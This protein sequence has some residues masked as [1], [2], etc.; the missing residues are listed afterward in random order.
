MATHPRLV[1]FSSQI[2]HSRPFP[3][4]YF[5]QTI[6]SNY[7]QLFLFLTMNPLSI[8]I[9][10]LI[11]TKC[12]TTST[13]DFT[14]LDKALD[15]DDL[16]VTA[17]LFNQNRQLHYDGFDRVFGKKSP[18]F[19]INLANKVEDLRRPALQNFYKTGTKETI[20]EALERVKFSEEDLIG[21]TSCSKLVCSPKE[22][23]DLL[24]RIKTPAG[25]GEA[26]ENG[27]EGLFDDNR[28]ECIDPLLNALE[29]KE[30]LGINLGNVALQALFKVAAQK[31]NEKWVKELYDHPALTHA[32]YGPVL[33]A[34]VKNDRESPACQWLLANADEGSFKH[35]KL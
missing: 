3:S 33:F 28:T 11:I 16:E 24:N 7:L 34:S 17:K 27:I 32:I 18:H 21:A 2:R 6:L 29:D 13:V 30:L 14:E 20:K 9:L 5:Q 35:L 26:L 15:E 22:L 25:Q 1:K 31:R 10:T 23:L 8:V 19:I 4:T 12:V